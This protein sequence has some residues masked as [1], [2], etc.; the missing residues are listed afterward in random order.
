MSP[1]GLALAAFLVALVLITT[2]VVWTAGESR[3][4]V[5]APAAEP[6]E[7]SRPLAT[8]SALADRCMSLAPREVEAAEVTLKSAGMRLVG[9]VLVPPD[10][11]RD[12]GVIL[13]PEIGGLC[14]SI[15]FAEALAGEGVSAMPIDPC[16]FGGSTCAKDAHISRQVTIAADHLR[17]RLSVRRV[18]LVGASMGGSQAVRAVAG[19]ARVDAWADI[20]GPSAWDGDRLLELAPQ[21]SRP[22]FVAFAKH[23]GDPAEFGRARALAQRSQ[24]VFAPASNGHGWELLT[25]LDGGLTTMGKRLVEFAVATNVR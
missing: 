8:P 19:G 2:A 15:L 13:L 24:A 25:R 1:K 18:V 21:V 20:S 23:D 11:R 17:H 7:R 9:A 22:G 16:G 4:T 6:P 5:V 14:G 3:R 10:S 12:V